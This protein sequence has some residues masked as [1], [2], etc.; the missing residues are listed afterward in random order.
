MNPIPRGSPVC[1][2][3]DCLRYDFDILLSDSNNFNTDKKKYDVIVN[4]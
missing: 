3:E 1:A 4:V 2:K